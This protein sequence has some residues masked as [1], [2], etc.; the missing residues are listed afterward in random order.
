[1]PTN[2]EYDIPFRTE[3]ELRH[4]VETA[5][6]V[7]IPDTHVCSNHATP[8]E[9]FADAYFARHSTSVWKASRGFGG[10]T[11]L[12]GLLALTEAT[13]LKAS[14]AVL[15]G[16]GEQSMRV[17][18]HMSRFWNYPNAPR[19]LLLGDVQREMRFAWGNQVQALMASQASTRGPHPQRLRLDEIDVMDLKILDAATGQPMTGGTGIPIQTVMSSTHQVSGGTMDEVLKRAAE[20]NWG[21]FEW[22]YR[23]NLEPHGWLTWAEVETKR[24]DVTQAIWDNEYELQAPNPE[25]RAIQP[26]AVSRMFK[27]ALGD[28]EGAVYEEI[29]I[30]KPERGALYATGIDWAKEVNDT[31]IVT[32]RIDAL[33]A[34]LV[35]FERT[36]RE[37]WPVMIAKAVKRIQRYPG[38]ACHDG[39]GLGDVIDDLIQDALRN[40]PN[41]LGI[42]LSGMLRQQILND[43]VV[44]IE[45]NELIAPFIKFMERQHRMASRADLY[46]TSDKKHHLPDT[47]A[48]GALMYHAA[49]MPIETQSV[50]VPG[51]RIGPRW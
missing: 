50:V 7:R 15:G 46:A 43:Y 2:Y 39:T 44:G 32:F 18:E 37:E 31:I 42:W 41:V 27:P 45:N 4:F 29:V 25:S 40:V 21:L 8:W 20:K 23:E 13:T 49:T 17:Q 34:K 47:I 35:A 3:F 38:P 33:P 10:K 9:A 12:L 14:G 19:Q 22:C 1:M 51:A 28:F 6:G 5:F 11:F 30:E 36:Q 48:A 24:R 26:S 16:S